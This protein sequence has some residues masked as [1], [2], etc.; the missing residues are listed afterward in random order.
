MNKN[1]LGK[2]NKYA[3]GNSNLRM[4]FSETRPIG[5][6]TTCAQKVE[7]RGGWSKNDEP[8]SIETKLHKRMQRPEK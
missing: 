8:P 6:K 7:I 4:L 1:Y 3:Q 2:M 5:L